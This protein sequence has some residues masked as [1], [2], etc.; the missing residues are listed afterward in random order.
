MVLLHVRQEGFGHFGDIGV[1][2]NLVHE[3]RVSRNRASFLKV[4]DGVVGHANSLDKAL[5]DQS[6]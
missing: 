6:F 3:N 2:L 1:H 4:L 5:V